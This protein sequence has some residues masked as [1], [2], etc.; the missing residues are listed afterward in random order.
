MKKALAEYHL[1]VKR[2]VR[3]IVIV[4]AESEDDAIEEAYTAYWQDDV[5]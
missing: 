5:Q 2:L 4:E 3:G 1:Q